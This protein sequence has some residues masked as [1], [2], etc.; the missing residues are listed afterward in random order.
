MILFSFLFFF[1]LGVERFFHES[2]KK[3]KKNLL[4]QFLFQS[5]GPWSQNSLC[6]NC[7]ATQRRELFG[8]CNL[9]GLAGRALSN[10]D[11]LYTIHSIKTVAC[12]LSCSVPSGASS[13]AKL[14]LKSLCLDQLHRL[15]SQLRNGPI[16]NGGKAF[17]PS[18]Y[19][20]GGTEL[21]GDTL[22]QS[23]GVFG[24]LVLGL[25]LV[26][27]G[28]GWHWMSVDQQSLPCV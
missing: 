9:V 13:S 18:S 28:T 1:F 25:A 6:T 15:W 12:V 21:P 16:I 7:W 23:V 2:K 20:V 8:S 22:G 3:K 10:N 27:F 24:A 26:S 14:P 5:G 17:A 19:S 11:F 4:L